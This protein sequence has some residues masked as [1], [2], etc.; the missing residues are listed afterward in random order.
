MNDLFM[1]VC[2]WFALLFMIMIDTIAINFIQTVDAAIN[3]IIL[4]VIV[5][6]S[7]IAIDVIYEFF[8]KNEI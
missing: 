3:I 5:G 6:V 7:A 8:V 4:N 2:G 1:K